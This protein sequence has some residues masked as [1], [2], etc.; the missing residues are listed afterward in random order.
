MMP[1]TQ[2]RPAFLQSLLLLLLL[3]PIVL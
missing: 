1:L 2:Y 3:L